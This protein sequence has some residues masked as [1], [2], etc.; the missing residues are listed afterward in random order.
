MSFRSLSCLLLLL[1]WAAGTVS[2]QQQQPLPSEQHASAVQ[3]HAALPL[4]ALPAVDEAALRAEDARGTDRIGPSRYGTVLNTTFSP[5]RTGTWEQLP[6]GNW[7]WRLRLQS[8][9]AVSM[10]VGLTPFR[11]PEGARLYLHGPK[12][13][14]VRGPYTADDATN[15]QLWT[16][17]VRGEEVI[18][19]LEVPQDRRS[20]VTLGVAHVVHGYR[21]LTSARAPGAK[22]GTC[23]LDVA[24]EEADPW[25]PQV[26]SVG[27]YTFRRNQSALTC[28]GALVNNTAQDGRPLFLT[29]EHCVS[30]AQAAA[31]MV[32][33]WNFQTSTC[34][35]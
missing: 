18:L 29:A 11:L 7:L 13:D 15:G 9:D 14:L 28:S 17:L 34:R 16:P 10:S 3:T 21:S 24:C 33:Y 32:F 25:R 4:E 19:E 35:T 1:P 26:R 31:S 20:A 5:T 30:N 6:S 22:S 27:G 2:A 23:N 12:G 8:R